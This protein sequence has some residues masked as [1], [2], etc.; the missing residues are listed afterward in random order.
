MAKIRFRCQ[1][2]Q[3]VRILVATV[4]FA[5]LFAVYNGFHGVIRQNQNVE[6]E[7][8]LEFSTA[9]ELMQEKADDQFFSL[10]QVASGVHV[11]PELRKV[12]LQK[13]SIVDM[14]NAQS[15]LDKL[16]AA[17]PLLNNVYYYI[18]DAQTLITR[19]GV[20]HFPESEPYF[21]PFDNIGADRMRDILS[22]S[23]SNSRLYL[24][25]AQ[26]N[27]NSIGPLIVALLPIPYNSTALYAT[28]MLEMRKDKLLKLIL[29]EAM[30]EKKAVYRVYR[31][32]GSLL[33][34]TEEG[35]FTFLSS[36]GGNALPLYSLDN[37]AYY[38]KRA[39]K[40]GRMKLTYEMY[41]PQTVI[42]EDLLSQMQIDLMRSG[43][44]IFLLSLC[45]LLYMWIYHP[46]RLLIEKLSASPGDKTKR[47][48]F[49]NDY[50]IVMHEIERL[51][52][53]NCSLLWKVDSN[54]NS[55]RA[56]LLRRLMEYGMTE[57]MADLCRQA[58]LIFRYP[59]FRLVLIAPQNACEMNL[60]GEYYKSSI[61][62]A[63]IYAV[64]TP[65][66][67]YILMNADVQ[68]DACVHEALAS[69][70]FCGLTAQ[71]SNLY[72]AFAP[73]TAQLPEIHLE[74]RRTL[75]TLSQRMFHGLLGW[76]EENEGIGETVNRQYPVNEMIRLRESIMDFDK[77]HIKQAVLDIQRYMLQEHTKDTI[78][79]L[80]ADNALQILQKYTEADFS[81]LLLEVRHEGCTAL[82]VCHILNQSLSIIEQMT[83]QQEKDML[84]EEMM[85]YI[86]E[87]LENPNLSSLTV[88]EHFGMSDSAFSHAFKK[89]T[90]STFVKY[91]TD[92]KIQR[93]KSLL[94]C[95]EQS[96]E[97]IAAT[98]NYASASSFARMFKGET[99]LTPTQYRRMREDT[100]PV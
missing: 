81:A 95:T 76:A 41:L 90:G 98:L 8:L 80:A 93:A 71:E 27:A 32:D 94:I 13:Y 63:D 87:M 34:T 17:N 52:S 55:V 97:E 23:L 92:L 5:L 54:M 86:S 49:Q 57:K 69:L 7:R 44:L 64:S 28:M 12:A 61:Q 96:V 65:D 2:S 24:F 45:V 20:Y 72:I 22:G 77:D 99:S 21:L 83:K 10:L 46:M 59:F 48:I 100:K 15:E 3:S 43:F 18:I 53:S 30:N 38:A 89:R 91:V 75:D 56:S 33:L 11:N 67:L 62:S 16:I 51:R 19:S 74:Y 25:S 9:F 29:P 4:L 85:M 79:V 78:A 60:N 6:Q 42:T 68:T 82:E 66:I 14:L 58:D 36:D 1:I 88:S 39:E 73:W 26:S 84:T 50:G 37:T 35:E 47:L 31:E 70:S 40:M